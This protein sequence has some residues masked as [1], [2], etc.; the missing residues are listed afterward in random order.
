MGAA[1]RGDQDP[2]TRVA[3]GLLD[4]E[5]R[6]WAQLLRT[7]RRQSDLPAV[8]AGLLDRPTSALAAGPRRTELCHALAHA[9]EVLAVLLTDP[10]LPAAAHAVI[11][12][13]QSPQR[14][15]DGSEPT[16]APSAED[17]VRVAT[18]QRELRRELAE[19][20][21]QR[22]GADARAA[23]AAAR[24]SEAEEARVG[25]EQRVLEL[26][27]E[28]AQ[29]LEDIANAAARAERRAAAR[30]EEL[31]RAL[32]AERSALEALRRERE[33]DRAVLDGLRVELAEARARS[34]EVEAPVAVAARPLVLPEELDADTTAAA[35]W[36][37]DG[38]RVL[39][40]DGYNVS[41]ALRAGHPLVEQRRWLVERLRPLAVRGRAT[42]VVVFD[43]DGTGSTQRDPSGV[44][45]RF[46]ASGTIADDEIVFIVAATEDPVL[47]ITDDA[48]LR[49]RVIAEGGNVLGT[50]H[51]LGAIEP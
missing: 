18:R 51:L 48:E 11:A 23:V 29:A 39:L 43:G 25:L 33:R 37:L 17:G 19:L 13:G 46:T 15:A 5:S 6:A 16:D 7:L 4:L 40:V 1:S 30:T 38:A 26:E 10:A 45:I 36:L 2:A 3:D 27:R 49:G 32:A 35:K 12:S 50:V 8:I 22:E 9:R 28:L 44:E 34:V 47:V 42:P 31:E 20:R 41:L 24:A 14:E 21:R